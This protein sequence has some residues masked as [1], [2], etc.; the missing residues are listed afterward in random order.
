[1]G[2]TDR[3]GNPERALNKTMLFH[4]PGEL[5]GGGHIGRRWMI[6]TDTDPPGEQGGGGHIGRRWMTEDDTVPPG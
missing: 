4:Q 1:M 2:M 6:A 5:G 3:K